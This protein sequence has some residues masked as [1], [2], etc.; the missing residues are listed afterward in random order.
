MRGITPSVSNNPASTNLLSNQQPQPTVHS[1]VLPTGL[2]RYTIGAEGL[3]LQPP[4]KYDGSVEGN[5]C[6]EWIEEMRAYM[7]YYEKR[8]VFADEKEKI[9]F[10]QGYL[11]DTAKRV[12]TARRK[13][14]EGFPMGHAQ[15]VDTLERFFAVLLHACADINHQERVRMEYQSIVQTRDV[16]RYV[17][18]VLDLRAQ[19]NPQPP[20]FEVREKIKSGLKDHVLDELVKILDVPTDL[21]SFIDLVERIDRNLYERGRIRHQQS[22]RYSRMAM[23]TRG[24]QALPRFETMRSASITPSASTPSRAKPTKGTPAWSTWCQENRACYNCGNTDHMSRNCPQS[25]SHFRDS[26]RPV[27]SQR[28][29]TPSRSRSRSLGRPGPS[30]KT[31]STKVKDPK[32]GKTY[33]PGR[34]GKGRAR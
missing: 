4:P 27:Q 24:R 16:R 22:N 14:A 13:Y 12:W 30:R 33:Y 5:A 31:T 20:E 15:R 18:E 3:K 21:G 29:H 2:N 28:Q 17:Y 32:N 7:S 8:S 6:E 34:S 19:L 25:R 9:D 1:H 26:L 23:T 10:A 11:K